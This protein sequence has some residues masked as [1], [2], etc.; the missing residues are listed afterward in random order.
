MIDVFLLAVAQGAGL[1]VGA[2]LA[3]A[4]ILGVAVKL[5]DIFS[6]ISAVRQ[7]W[8]ADQKRKRDA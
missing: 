3:I 8:Y 4:L 5:P 7:A 6:T 1:L 2:V